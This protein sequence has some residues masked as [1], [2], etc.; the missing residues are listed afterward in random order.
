MN[1]QLLSFTLIIT[2]GIAHSTQAFNP[3]E[4]LATEIKISLKKF[5]GMT[6]DTISL[7]ALGATFL[8]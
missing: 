5:G 1:K 3:A 4:T 7:A 8:E 2:L 6:L